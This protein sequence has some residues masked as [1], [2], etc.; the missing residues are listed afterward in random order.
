MTVLASAPEVVINMPFFDSGPIP[1]PRF[2]PPDEVPT[3]LLPPV[4]ASSSDAMVTAV[5]SVRESAMAA[6]AT[7]AQ[8]LQLPPEN[9]PGQEDV[10][11]YP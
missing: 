1:L 8:I 6:A 9:S 11:G 7:I 5:R 4:V 2:T 3:E 10:D